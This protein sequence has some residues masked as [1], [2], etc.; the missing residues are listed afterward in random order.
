MTTW[1]WILPDADT[2]RS[3]TLG[4]APR[5]IIEL[6]E[7]F[8]SGEP[9]ISSWQP[10]QLIVYKEEGGSDLALGDFPALAGSVPLLVSSIAWEVLSP[11]IK[12]QVECLAVDCQDNHYMALNVQVISALDESGSLVKRDASSGEIRRVEA[13]AFIKGAVG[14]QHI[15]RLPQE[16][17][18]RT[19]VDGDFRQLVLSSGLTGLLFFDVPM[20][21]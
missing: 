9:L 21:E 6:T 8:R 15:F 5:S 11:L 10:P 19:F 4:N 20:N 1:W 16:S 14:D 17:L 13:Y 3:Y 12:D 18:K 7:R 2:Y